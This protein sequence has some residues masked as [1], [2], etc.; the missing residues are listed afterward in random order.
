MSPLPAIVYT[1][2]Y[3]LTNASFPAATIP[4][5]SNY[6]N[7][8]APFSSVAYT[9]DEAPRPLAGYIPV[10]VIPAGTVLLLALFICITRLNKRRKT[11]ADA[12]SNEKA[13]T[14]YPPQYQRPLRPLRPLR[15]WDAYTRSQPLLQLVELNTTPRQTS[16]LRAPNR[17]A[18]P[19]G[20]L[21]GS[22]ILTRESVRSV[23]QL[24]IYT[25]FDT[26]PHRGDCSGR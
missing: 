9:S 1:M 16:A 20:R 8:T 24:P 23:E 25:E 13:S 15:P 17:A 5:G 22:S 7:A 11:K 12:T 2:G 21:N 14:T 10:F 18:F 6:T 3:L 26:S 19:S 4:Q